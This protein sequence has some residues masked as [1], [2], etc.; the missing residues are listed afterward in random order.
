MRALRSSLVG[1][2]PDGAVTAVAAAGGDAAD[3]VVP[4]E[5]A[6]GAAPL[7]GR[8]AD[9]AAGDAAVPGGVLLLRRHSVE[10]LTGHC[11]RQLGVIVGGAVALVRAGQAAHLA[12]AAGRADAEG[13]VERRRRRAAGA[14]GPVG[15]FLG[16][17][18]RDGLMP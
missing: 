6:A 1:V 16:C 18:G 7:G 15:R 10:V 9:G 12:A 5:V 11:R 4:A 8:A 17:A 2:G 13:V 14:R 3:G